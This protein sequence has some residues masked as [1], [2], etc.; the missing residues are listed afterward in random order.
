MAN[1][2]GNDKIE[3][4]AGNGTLERR[5]ICILIYVLWTPE[6]SILSLRYGSWHIARRP[7]ATRPSFS[8]G[9]RPLLSRCS[10]YGSQHQTKQLGLNIY[11]V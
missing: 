10:N 4:D 9:W 5:T 3:G 1:N 7:Y 8:A 11:E 6:N 2:P